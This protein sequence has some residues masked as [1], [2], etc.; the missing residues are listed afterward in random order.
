MS[1]CPERILLVQ[2]I[3]VLSRQEILAER[4]HVRQAL[5]G[6]RH[7]AGVAQVRESALPKVVARVARRAGDG[8][9]VVGGGGERRRVASDARTAK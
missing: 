4:R 7:E 2:I 6:R 8:R 3:H 5:E 1:L 9:V